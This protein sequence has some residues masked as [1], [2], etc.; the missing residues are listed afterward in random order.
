MDRSRIA[1]CVLLSFM[2]LAFVAVALLLNWIK[3]RTRTP[4]ADRARE[5]HRH[6]RPA[7]V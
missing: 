1:T 5:V 7:V 2:A 4:G 6:A 3:A